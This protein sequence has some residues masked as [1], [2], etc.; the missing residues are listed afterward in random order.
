MWKYLNTRRGK[1]FVAVIVLTVLPFLAAC[2][3]RAREGTETRAPTPEALGGPMFTPVP[4]QTETPAGT[5]AIPQSTSRKIKATPTP[6]RAGVPEIPT[7]ANT[8][9]AGPPSS[10][11]SELINGAT[12][13]LMALDVRPTIDDAFVFLRVD[14]NILEGFDGCNS[15]WGRHEDG[16]PVAV[17]DGT[18]SPPSIGG[19]EEGC[20][21]H[22]LDQGESY[23][24]AVMEG[25]R[26]RATR[27]RLE[28]LD[29]AGNVRLVF[30]RLEDLPG[31]AANLTG[32][33]W[34]LIYDGD[35]VVERSVFTLAFLEDGLGAGTTACR[36]FV[37]KYRTENERID[38]SATSMIGSSTDCPAGSG[39]PE[40]RF[41]TDLSRA[42]EYSVEEREAQ[43]LLHFR[44]S[45][46]RTLIFEELPQGLDSIRDFEWRLTA[47][48]E[49]LRN[50]SMSLAKGTGDA[51]PGTEVT[52]QFDETGLWGSTGC[53][54]YASSTRKGPEGK[55]GPIVR[56]DGSVAQELEG[57]VTQR[58]CPETPGAM[59]QESRFLELLPFF[60]RIQVF[61]DR[62]A[63]HTEPGVFLLFQARHL[64]RS[65]DTD[66]IAGE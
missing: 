47:F 28:I 24:E 21:D 64:H 3:D 25:D 27:D 58:G 32:T 30:T 53:N 65:E 36:D 55:S 66:R 56:K 9:D 42:N 57:S 39:R 50:G 6:S 31:H 35:G 38:F 59:E 52:L 22:I 54:S 13:V 46:G 63:I 34:R 16:T 10:Q 8:E 37:A 44:T 29:R 1:I 12:W 51:V 11:A 33:Q 17:I 15:L 45:R 62:L 19:T 18:F 7:V 43:S 23:V 14:G 20:P 60:Q 4:V 48:V 49:S 61:G 41:T 2:T 26:F 5:A 40:G